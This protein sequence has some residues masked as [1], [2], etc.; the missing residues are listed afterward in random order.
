M[1]NRDRILNMLGGGLDPSVVASAVGV[2]PAYISQL[3]AEPEFALAVAEKR[4]IELTQAKSIDDKWD[5]YE[6]MLL[7]KLEDLI[8][9]FSTPKHIIDALKLVNG[10]KRK[11]ALNTNPV[12][13]TGNNYVTI[14]MPVVLVKAYKITQ[15]GGMVEVEGRS[16]K[17]MSSGLL[18]KTLKDRNGGSDGKEPKLLDSVAQKSSGK[19]REISV[20]S[21]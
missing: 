11:T 16:L 13:Q 1:D 2:T 19:T 6:D 15:A 8:P 21:I 3:L 9:Y 4:T 18:L 10:A 7:E 17:P 12:G 5:K 14:N 20:D